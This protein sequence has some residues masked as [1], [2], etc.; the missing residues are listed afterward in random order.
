MQRDSW[1]ATKAR[2]CGA[3][4]TRGDGAKAGDVCDGRRLRV[5]ALPH[6]RVV[7]RVV[8]QLADDFDFFGDL[9]EG[10]DVCEEV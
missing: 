7:V 3:F 9:R 8:Q 2:V 10:V 5:A 6:L 4:V 1:N